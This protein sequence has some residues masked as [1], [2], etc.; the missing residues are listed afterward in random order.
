MRGDA[1]R[2]DRLAAGAG[3]FF[4]ISVIVQN[5]LRSS[6]PHG[7]ASPDK[8]VA[9]FATHRAAALISL[10]LF[11]LGMVALF[12]FVSGVTSNRDADATAAWWSRVGLLGTVVIAALFALVNTSDIV[13]AAKSRDLTAAPDV[14][15]AVWAIHGAAFSLNMAAIGAALLGLSRAALAAGVLPRWLDVPSV[16]GSACLP[17]SGCFA[18]ATVNGGAAVR[19]V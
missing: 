10:G 18:A 17:V 16:V 11:P 12:F 14:V 3:A 5:V 13:L 8:V 2:T 1:L 19:S 9:Y 6:E 15:R 4:V 7:D